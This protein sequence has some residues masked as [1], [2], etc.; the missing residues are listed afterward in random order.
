M[1]KLTK[2]EGRLTY[3]LNEYNSKTSREKVLCSCECGKQKLIRKDGIGKYSLSC[4][5]LRTERR[6]E[7]LSK[8][9]MSRTPTYKSWCSMKNRCL[10]K[11][12]PEYKNY[13]GRGISFCVRWNSFE[14][15]L[16]DMGVRPKDTTLDRIDNEG[17]YD[18][19][20]CRW[21]TWEIQAKNKRLKQLGTSKHQGV[22]FSR[23]S[24][25]WEVVVYENK[26]KKR[27]G[28]FKEEIDATKCIKNYRSKNG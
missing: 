15:F 17:N 27:L 4:G 10:N 24:K 14:K 21:A 8:H 26:K 11:N 28:S 25:K 23:S 3:N 9:N 6:V 22:Y 5:C 19:K 13:G 20:N 12:V 16:A 1:S 18:P 2:K 7:K